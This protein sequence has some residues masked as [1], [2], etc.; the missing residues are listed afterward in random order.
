M[1]TEQEEIGEFRTS[2]FL[3]KRGGGELVEQIAG[4]ALVALTCSP[5]LPATTR[6]ADHFLRGNARRLCLTACFACVHR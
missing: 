6:A 5:G 2:G 4:Y 1:Y 3:L